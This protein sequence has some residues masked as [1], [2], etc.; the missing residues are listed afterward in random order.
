MK[1]FREFHTVIIGGGQAGLSVSYHL[2]LEGH[3]HIVFEQAAQAA[4]TW[5]NHRW[6]SFTLNNPNWQSQLQ[7]ANIPGKDPDGF[8]SRDELVSYFEEYIQQNRLPVQYETRVLTVRAVA[9]GYAVETTAGTFR[10]KN[11]VVATGVC[12]PCIPRFKGALPPDIRQLHSDS[13]RNPDSLPAGAVLVVGS[14]QS[15][16]QIAEEL[17]QSGRRV[18]LSVS[19]SGRVPRRYRGRDINWWRN[20]LDLYESTVDQ[21]TSLHEVHRADT[22]S[23]STG[24]LAMA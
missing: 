20:A 18:Y 14:A 1:Q 13:Y 15:G 7:G 9:D 4:N 8:L 19:S 12:Q 3:D 22:R 6:D 23:T 24:L 10:A 11:V 2:K 16:A 17:Y 5:R 21:L